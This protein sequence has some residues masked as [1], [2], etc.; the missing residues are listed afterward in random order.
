MGSWEIEE[1]TKGR[2]FI[3]VL[4]QRMSWK[5][6]R[7]GDK[8]ATCR[9]LGSLAGGSHRWREPQGT[10]LPPQRGDR[11]AFQAQK[12]ALPAAQCWPHTGTTWGH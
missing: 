10:L 1:E 7:G 12:A 3:P 8:M 9:S 6:G 5:D 11:W 4:E 2:H